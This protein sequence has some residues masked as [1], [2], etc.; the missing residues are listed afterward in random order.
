MHLWVPH[1]SDALWRSLREVGPPVR[2]VDDASHQHVGHPLLSSLGRDSRELQ[3]TLGAVEVLDVPVPP[4]PAAPD[5]LL[6]WLQSDLRANAE[7]DQA[8]RASRTWERSDRSVQVHACHGTGRQVDVLRE[9]LLGL[10]AADPTLEPRDLLVMCPDIETYAPLISAGFGLADVV[11][12]QGHPAHQLRV[13]LADRSLT[14]TNPLLAVATALL[15]LAG[16]RAGASQVLDLAHAEPVRR[17]FGFGDDELQQLAV[18]VRESGV[19]WAF[20]AEHRA[21]FGLAD[22]VSNTWQFGLDRLLTGVAMSDDSATWLDRTLPLDDVGSGQ[23]DL[24]GRLA[25]F[26]ARLRRVTDA[27][28]GAHPL[29]HWLDTVVDGLGSLTAVAGADAWQSAQVQ[30]ELA[31]V[32]ESARGLGVSRLRLPDVRALLD[33]RLAGRP[34][35]ANFRTGTLTVCTMV[36]MRSVPHRVVCLLG[37]DDGVFPRG[38]A[39]D[40]DDVLARDPVTGERDPR[41]E[42]RQLML[43][44][45]LAA[46]ETLVVTY[47]GADEY[48]GARRPPAV[49]LGELLDALDRT[50][51]APVA[52]RLVV[53]HPLQPFDARNLTPGAL[54][55]EEAFSFDRA[56][57]SGARA[58]AGA[59]VVTPRLLDEPLPAR[60]AGDVSLDDLVRFFKAPARA[61]LRQRLD[62]ALADEDDPI[63]D[64]M[65]VE[66]DQLAQWSVGDR[67]LRD[68]LGGMSV[69]HARE[70]EWRRGVLPPKWLG[71]RVLGDLLRRA[72]PLAVEG[73]RM[74]TLEPRAVEVDVDLG[75]GRRLRGTVAQVYGD[76]LVPVHYS[77]LGASHRMEAWVQLLALAATD[78]DRAWSAHAI[79]RPTSSRGGAALASSQLG[80]LDHRAPALLRDLVALREIGLAAP[81]PLPLK[82]SLAYARARRTHA[83][84]EQALDKVRWDWEDGRFPGE[85]SDPAHLRLWPDKRLPGLDEQPGPGE[86]HAGETTRFGALSQ[87]VWSPLIAAEQ[88]SW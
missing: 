71:W 88:G 16:G 47:T 27:L 49:P 76:R 38:G 44:A 33:D 31:R 39:P 11:R 12:D 10:L 3:R 67:V 14:Q 59:R 35:R 51:A 18:W 40:G 8:A 26:V 46:T 69:E 50:A 37:L 85:C 61:F 53:H 24:V 55:V 74:R 28:V 42:D 72:E 81:L 7:P 63:E 21:D 9:V 23:I 20:D 80:P 45:V 65:P 73:R 66:I 70:Q 25:E 78:D 22:Y 52:D 41:S 34:T 58:A 77:R 62:L 60:T 1:P 43:D 86:E 83:P 54:G 36:P 4:E 79:G 5:S 84:V 17:R 87:R 68:L 48:S 30:A 15:E 57:L 2:R 82:S 32:R 75:D 64:G 6:G 13:R 29:E 19:R 56:A